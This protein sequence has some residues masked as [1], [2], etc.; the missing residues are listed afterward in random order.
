MIARPISHPGPIV[1][2]TSKGEAKV[3]MNITAADSNVAIAHDLFNASVSQKAVRHR[4]IQSYE[5]TALGIELTLHIRV[6]QN[7]NYALAI[8]SNIENIG[9]GTFQPFCYYLVSSKDQCDVMDSFPVVPNDVI[10]AIY[11]AFSELSL[12]I[13]GCLPSK[14][15]DWKHGMVKTDDD[16]EVMLFLGHEKPLT[17]LADFSSTAD[18][19]SLNKFLCVSTIGKTTCIV[20]RT[21]SKDYG[22]VPYLIKVYAAD[23]GVTQQIPSVYTVIVIPHSANITAEEFFE[24]PSRAWG[25]IGTNYFK[26]DI[27]GISFLHSISHIKSKCPL[28][29]FISSDCVRVYKGGDDFEFTLNH[30]H[31]LQLKTTLQQIDQTNA[32]AE[33]QPLDNL[34]CMYKAD[35][36][37]SSLKI[38]VPQTGTYTLSVFGSHVDNASGQLSP[39]IYISIIANKSSSETSPFPTAFGVW[40]ASARL[41]HQPFSSSLLRNKENTVKLYL[42]KFEK[43]YKKSEEWKIVPYPAVAFVADGTVQIQPKS[44][45]DDVYEWKYAPGPAEKVAGILV[46]ADPTSK[47][48]AYALQF[49]I[50]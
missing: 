19:Q 22:I 21:S 25:P 49:Q 44:V 13:E 16:G 14:M 17:V 45:I 20:A 9:S 12:T 11:P 43:P 37:S 38:R 27:T 23:V 31:P 15:I 2:C 18:S 35:A 34:M 10:G 33:Q 8:Y 1:E 6:P 42:A 41:L 3:V 32:T 24:S 50:E 4:V 7:G 26:H 39:L 48:M 46:K 47:S 28:P 29:D 5:K 36:K 40:A 30:V